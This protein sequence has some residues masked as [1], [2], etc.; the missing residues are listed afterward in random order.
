M[1]AI[2]WYGKLNFLFHIIYLVLQLVQEHS[3]RSLYIFSFDNIVKKGKC[4]IFLNHF[5]QN[6][7]CKDFCV[8]NF[9]INEW[10]WSLVQEYPSSPLFIF[11]FGG[12][13]CIMDFSAKRRLGGCL[14][15]GEP[16][17]NIFLA[18]FSWYF[19]ENLTRKYFRGRKCHTGAWGDASFRVIPTRER[20]PQNYMYLK[21]VLRKDSGA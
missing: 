1:G 18:K 11:S 21:F 8:S 10:F 5:F 12:K 7:T 3:F 13:V 2:Y 16:L 9:K 4:G 17:Q 20:M 14:P 6:K 19:F 15:L